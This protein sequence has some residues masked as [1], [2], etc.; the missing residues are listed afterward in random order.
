MIAISLR[1]ATTATL[2][3][4]TRPVAAQVIAE[5]D[6]PA[7]IV[8]LDVVEKN[9]WRFQD[10]CDS[11]RLNLRP[12]IKTHKIPALARTQ[13]MAG[14]I[15]INCQKVSEAEVMAD[16]GIDDILITFNILGTEKLAKLR[17]LSERCSL[18]VT[19]DDPAVV[20][21]LSAVFAGSPAPLG[22]L[23]E[24]D[25]GAQRCGVQTPK[26]ATELAAKIVTAPGLEFRGLM[27]YP[28]AGRNTEADDWLARAK[29]HC[30]ES[31]LPCPIVSSGG[32]PDMWSAEHLK[33]ATEYRVGTY[34]YNDRS[35]VDRGVCTLGDCALTIL[36]T[37]VSRPTADRAILDT[38]SKSLTSDLLGL[39]GFGTI[40][41]LPEAVIY[42][43]NEE[44]GFLDLSAI[45][46]KPGIG[47]KVRI[48]PNH[49]CVVSNLVDHV[50]AVRGA[51]VM[52]TLAVGARGCST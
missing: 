41:D 1:E 28:P 6:T 34:I 37:V 39:D 20:A 40:P 45:R 24:C 47:D 31:G 4:A 19:A 49:A 30:E 12:H 21:G 3:K 51:K 16:A 42:G 43:L 46:S 23:V 13:L 7:V 29:G 22:V 36:A 9:I 48:I 17:R 35:L 26:A 2:D 33:T 44:H 8:D 52:G 32:T 10:Y 25:T 11:H 5:I 18:S 27:T 15:G 14:A 38:G 50:Y